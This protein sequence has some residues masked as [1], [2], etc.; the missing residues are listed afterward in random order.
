[1]SLEQFS[2]VRSQWIALSSL[3]LSGIPSYGLNVDMSGAI[4]PTT[5]QV[6]SV[7]LPVEGEAWDELKSSIRQNAESLKG[8]RSFRTT[9]QRELEYLEHLIREAPTSVATTSNALFLCLFWQQ[10]LFTSLT[11]GPVVELNAV[12][13]V[14]VAGLFSTKTYKRRQKPN[15]RRKTNEKLAKVDIVG[16]GGRS[17]TRILTIKQSSLLAEFRIAESEIGVDSDLSDSDNA[18]A[19]EAASR[20]S[21]KDSKVSDSKSP[22]GSLTAIL[23]AQLDHATASCSL[24]RTVKDLLACREASCDGNAISIVLVVSRIELPEPSEDPL[25]LSMSF[26]STATENTRYSRRLQTISN[27]LSR[28]PRL[29]FFSAA[30]SRGLL[31]APRGRILPSSLASGQVG[32]ELPPTKGDF[33]PGLLFLPALPSPFPTAASLKPFPVTRDVNLDVSALVALV[34]DIT[35]MNIPLVETNF[36]SMFRA[37]GVKSIA[38]QDRVVAQGR[39]PQSVASAAAEHGDPLRK[40][41]FLHGRAL[42]L[43]LGVEAGQTRSFLGYLVQVSLKD[44]ASQPLRLWATKEAHEKF[45]EIMRLVGG[46]IEQKRAKALF[47][48]DR[49]TFWLGSRLQDRTEVRNSLLLPVKLHGLGMN[50]LCANDEVTLAASSSFKTIMQR[51]LLDGLHNVEAEG[52][53]AMKSTSRTNTRQT[54]HTLNS[55][56]CGLRVGMTTLTTNMLSIRWLVKECTRRRAELFLASEG[57][58]FSLESL[59]TSQAQEKH[60]LILVTNPRS[61]AERMRIDAANTKASE[62][63]VSLVTAADGVTMDVQNSSPVLLTPSSEAA[64]GQGPVQ[65]KKGDAFSVTGDKSGSTSSSYFNRLH[66]F[67][68]SIP[69]IQSNLDPHDLS[70]NE[71]VRSPTFQCVSASEKKSIKGKMV[72]SERGV[73]CLSTY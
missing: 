16:A 70:G 1:M 62:T 66:G 39:L 40:A 69:K 35:H 67:Y 54:P 17:W 41:S 18:S 59:N 43:Q 61:L 8:L 50:S 52:S 4:Q 11:C 32:Y 73:T 49:E 45:G 6:Q 68:S 19:A 63:G 21:L 38:A 5:D 57:T 23:F 42:A 46:P 56:L 64:P 22:E 51:I 33:D 30:S 10:V 37:S 7:R 20:S 47:Q 12:F 55:L 9:V 44:H 24:I 28:L 29:S 58:A 65:L 13:A 53:G 15:R 31:Q 34:S 27:L 26:V 36:K 2:T 3:T 71:T 25:G 60:A 72:A 14:P 48:G